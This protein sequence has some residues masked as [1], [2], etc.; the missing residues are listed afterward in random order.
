MGE[1]NPT[2]NFLQLWKNILSLMHPES[3]DAEVEIIPEASVEQFFNQIHAFFG[4][5]SYSKITSFVKSIFPETPLTI[6]LYNKRLEKPEYLAY[7]LKLSDSRW[8]LTRCIIPQDILTYTDQ[9]EQEQKVLRHLAETHDCKYNFSFDVQPLLK[10]IKDILETP[11]P[12]TANRLNLLMQKGLYRYRNSGRFWSVYPKPLIYKGGIRYLVY[13]LG[14]RLNLQKISH[15]SIPTLMQWG[16]N[17][18]LGLVHRSV[19]II[20]DSID[21]LQSVNFEKIQLASLW[22]IEN[23]AATEFRALTAE[24][25]QSKE[26]MPGDSQTLVRIRQILSEKYG[27]ITTILW[28]TPELLKNLVSTLVLDLHSHT[29]GLKNL[30]H[31][32]ELLQNTDHL[33]VEP[34]SPFY[35]LIKNEKPK[36]LLKI[37][38]PLITDLNEF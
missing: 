11:I 8:T 24:D 12:P 36:N 35:S 14:Y 37:L 19:I 28:F 15:W 7:H 26:E 18:T 9:I 34:E 32:L 4:E 16:I 22:T 10:F 1:P 5:I 30:S 3:N 31:T 17:S 25:L 21:D 23:G 6:T 20:S 27:Y 2:E 38:A 33:R 13:M 29:I